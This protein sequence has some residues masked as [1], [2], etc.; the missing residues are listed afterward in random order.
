LMG[1]GTSKEG[2]D[3]WRGV[4]RGLRIH[5]WGHWA[6]CCAA[7]GWV[8]AGTIEAVG[9]ACCVAWRLCSTRVP[10]SAQRGR[11]CRGDVQFRNGRGEGAGSA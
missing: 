1:V 4:K 7:G 6:R 5:R 2:L 9:G 10:V 3:T 8:Q 11:T